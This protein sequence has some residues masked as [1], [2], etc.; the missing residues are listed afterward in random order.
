MPA[1]IRERQTFA[2]LPKPDIA[3]AEILTFAGDTVSIPTPTLL[4]S[5]TRRVGRPS[6]HWTIRLSGQIT[7]ANGSASL[8]IPGEGAIEIDLATNE[9]DERFPSPATPR[10]LRGD[11]TLWVTDFNNS[12]QWRMDL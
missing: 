1:W 9:P 12:L 5:S 10:A 3:G 4:R 8:T 6:H 11:D 7:F 2:P